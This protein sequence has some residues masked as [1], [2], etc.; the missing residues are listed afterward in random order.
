[1]RPRGLPRISQPNPRMHLTVR[2]APA[3]GSRLQTWRETVG[4]RKSAE[5][6]TNVGEVGSVPCSMKGDCGIICVA[7]PERRH[8]CPCESQQTIE[9]GIRPMRT[10]WRGDLR[11]KS[12]PVFFTEHGTDPIPCT[13]ARSWF[14]KLRVSGQ[15][16]LTLSLSK[17]VER[18]F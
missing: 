17:G 18:T 10:W 14:D 13:H 3:S 4:L 12:S 6:P 7:S 2:C 15:R 8:R 9:A 1:M 11:G 16:P 5:F